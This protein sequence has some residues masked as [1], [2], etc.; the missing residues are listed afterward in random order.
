MSEDTLSALQNERDLLARDLRERTAQLEALTGELQQFAYAVSHDLRAPLRA[1]EGFAR[2]LLEDYPAKLD[3]EG[4]H[5]L[6]VILLSAHKSALL[7]DDLTTLSRLCGKSFAPACVKM[8]ELVQEKIAELREGGTTAVFAVG[9]LP[10][11]WGDQDLLAIVWEHLLSNAVK[12]SRQQSRPSVTVTGRT[13]G[14]QAIY[15]VRD[16]GVGFDP[17]RASRLFGLFQKL[18]EEAEFEGRGVGLATVRRLIHRH[19]GETWAEGKINKGATFFF[20]LPLR[21][22][23]AVR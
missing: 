9:S 3:A 12:F 17:A 22:N 5:A 4:K 14:R 13:E 11:A 21:E 23:A 10:E 16:N 1:M 2:I 15:E 18:H 19:G 6:E 20:S 8:E 7:L